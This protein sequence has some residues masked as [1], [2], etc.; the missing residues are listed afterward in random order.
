MRETVAFKT[1]HTG[2][3]SITTPPK[4]TSGYLDFLNDQVAGRLVNDPAFVEN[5]SAKIKV[6]ATI[7]EWLEEQ[8]DSY[9]KEL[10]NELER[11]AAVKPIEDDLFTEPD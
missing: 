8:P 6:S 9:S 11:L 2:S 10:D 1:Q 7:E 4:P 5:L 3:A